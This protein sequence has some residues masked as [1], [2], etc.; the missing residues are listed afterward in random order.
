MW[1]EIPIIADLCLC[2]QCCAVQ[3]TGKV[4]GNFVLWDL[5]ALL[6]LVHQNN[7]FTSVDLKDAYFHVPIYPPHKKFLQFV[8][9]GVRYEYRVILFGLSLCPRVFLHPVPRQQLPH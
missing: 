8:F 3:P 9:Q 6:H 4:I 7:W 1:D 5:G 2:L